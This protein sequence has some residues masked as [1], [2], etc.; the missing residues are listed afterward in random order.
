[1]ITG[2]AVG[3]I[4]M[5]L[6]ALFAYFYPNQ[7]AIIL[8]AGAALASLVD[9][10]QLNSKT[11]ASLLY[12]DTNQQNK[13]WGYI[14]LFQG[15]NLVLAPLLISHWISVMPLE[16]WPILNSFSYLISLA[17]ALLLKQFSVKNSSNNETVVKQNNDRFNMLIIVILAFVIGS[18]MVLIPEGG[19]KIL[20][21]AEGALRAE[22]L[23]S[24]GLVI[25]AA[26]ISFKGNVY[27]EYLKY[28]LKIGIY[29]GLI[30]IMF[31]YAYKFVVIFNIGLL[32]VGYVIPLFE[33]HINQLIQKHF[34]PERFSNAIADISSKMKLIT[35]TSVLLSA[36]SIQ[37]LGYTQTC[38]FVLSISFLVKILKL[39]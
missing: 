23:F 1:M 2:D 26:L 36:V 25:S 4:I 39:I 38:V 31:G 37:Y 33:I 13:F 21:G 22:F 29:S 15:I 24:L 18:I 27:A 10:I 35:G 28:V 6:L 8:I 5:L 19:S 32:I 30:L 20:G 3:T 16:T 11:H 9:F 7:G 34:R 17:F 14:Q 12:L